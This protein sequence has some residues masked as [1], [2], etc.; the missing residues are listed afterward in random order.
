L[1]TA[2][3]RAVVDSI[4]RVVAI[5]AR[6][7][8]GRAPTNREGEEVFAPSFSSSPSPF[9]FFSPRAIILSL[10]PLP[11]PFQRAILRVSPSRQKGDACGKAPRPR[12]RVP[13]AAREREKGEFPFSRA[14]V[15]CTRINR[16]VPRGRERERDEGGARSRRTRAISGAVDPRRFRPCLRNSPTVRAPRRRDIPPRSPEGASSSSSLRVNEWRRLRDPAS[17]HPSTSR[18]RQVRRRDTTCVSRN[19]RERAGSSRIV[20]V[21]VQLANPSC[22]VL[23]SR[24]QRFRV[25]FRIACVV[26]ALFADVA[27]FQNRRSVA[28]SDSAVQMDGPAEARLPSDSAT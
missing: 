15:F 19:V 28:I 3:R 5:E 18:R 2:S 11:V 17:Q 24:F 21:V 7:R 27:E 1:T 9:S 12:E 8:G 4:P 23:V 25:A 26:S 13:P 6:A 22:R 14:N 16:A 20:Q 10:R